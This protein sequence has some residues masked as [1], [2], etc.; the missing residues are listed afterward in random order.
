LSIGP[1]AP[2]TGGARIGSAERPWPMEDR[3]TPG[4]YLELG[5]I[6]PAEYAPRAAWLRRQPGVER[7]TWWANCKP[8]RDEL[9]MRVPDGTLL[10]VAEVDGSFRAPE[11]SG[12]AVAYHFRRHPRPSQG[13]LTGLPTTGLLVVWISPYQPELTEK[14]RDWGDF[15]HIRHIAAAAVPGF[16]QISV[17]ENVT[18]TD[19]QFMHFYELNGKDAETTF[20]GMTPEVAP[21]LGGLDSE[22]FAH[23]ADWKAAGGRL[24]YCNTFQLLGETG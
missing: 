23:W 4:L 19:P 18:G 7:V 24:I 8:G 2:A 6:D 3:T 16:A 15:V 5:N 21:R 13:I 14:L 22:E 12:P 11:P 17:Y 10:G 20:K 1:A 9:P